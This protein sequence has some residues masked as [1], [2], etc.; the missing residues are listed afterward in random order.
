MVKIEF[1]SKGEIIK[2]EFP[3]RW[4]EITL[5]QFLALESLTEP[6]EILAAIM[7]TDLTF[8]ENTKTN[9][10]PVMGRVIS[11]FNEKPPDLADRKPQGFGFQGKLIKLPRDID[12]MMFGQ[13]NQIYELL[14]EGVT[15]NLLKIMGI[16]LQPLMDGEF[17][18]ERQPYYEELAGS[19]PID[20][21]YAELFFF[22]ETLKKFKKYG[23]IGSMISI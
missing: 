11:I 23:S 5:R 12:N 14:E 15:K 22:A 10:A 1:K 13:V 3:E 8:L 20:D 16:A 2:A 4:S 19:L 6:I 17:I 21:T 9:L 7:R 18:E